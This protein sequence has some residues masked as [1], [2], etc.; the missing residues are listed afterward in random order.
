MD[1]SS[2]TLAPSDH[3]FNGKSECVNCGL[4]VS[5]GHQY[6]T[7]TRVLVKKAEVVDNV[8]A[9]TKD[10]TSAKKRKGGTAAKSTKRQKRN[11]ST[12]AKTSNS[13]GTVGF[14][15]G[16][17]PPYQTDWVTQLMLIFY[18]RNDG[19]IER[20]GM[21]LSDGTREVPFPLSIDIK[22][23]VANIKR[24]N[25]IKSLIED[26]RT[27]RAF[28][29]DTH[30]V[31]RF[32]RTVKDDLEYLPHWREKQ[33]KSSEPVAMETD[34]KETH[35][36]LV[37]DGKRTNMIWFKF[38]KEPPRYQT[39][40][41]HNDDVLPGPHIFT[42]EM[43]T[44]FI[45]FDDRAVELYDRSPEEVS[46][47]CMIAIK[48]T[49]AN[50]KSA[51]LIKKYIADGRTARA[52]VAM[53]GYQILRFGRQLVDERAATIEKIDALVTKDD[54]SWIVEDIEPMFT[55]KARDHWVKCQQNAMKAF[56]KNEKFPALM[57]T[58]LNDASR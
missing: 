22:N 13:T 47:P 6:P 34:T 51:N 25:V 9:E 8:V 46:F 17:P 29:S 37:E 31:L 11:E 27:A 42:V 16:A 35:E 10:S 52:F 38:D 45:Y 56:V 41:L 54:G 26:G 3:V 55:T 33:V 32:G 39:D 20:H 50:L 23:N 36:Q 7:C 44:G 2:T 24:A 48:N 53:G 4:A 28:R 49:A 21:G 57:L 43:T 30:L 18:I 12:D 58:S 15:F 5:Y 1:V 14:A 19:Y 40:Y